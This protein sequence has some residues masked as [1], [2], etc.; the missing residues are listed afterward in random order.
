M[1]DQKH[2]LRTKGDWVEFRRFFFLERLGSVLQ[3]T[4]TPCY[5]WVLSPAMS[6]LLKLCDDF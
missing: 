2:S 3:K 1:S 4:S 5:G 6:R